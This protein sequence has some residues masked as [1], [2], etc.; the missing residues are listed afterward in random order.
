L[1]NNFT[2]LVGFPFHDLVEGHAERIFTQNANS[3]RRIRTAGFSRP[4]DEFSEVQQKSGFHL[5]FERGLR[6]A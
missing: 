5:V 3:K 6:S 4:L 1:Y 2:A